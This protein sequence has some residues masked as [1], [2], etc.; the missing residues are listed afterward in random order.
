MATNAYAY[1][2]WKKSRP[3]VRQALRYNNGM[4]RRRISIL[5]VCGLHSSRAT[6]RRGN[7][8]LMPQSRL[9][10][11]ELKRLLRYLQKRSAS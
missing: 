5:R 8:V 10:A 2:L 6:D 3:L 4:I 11:V 9:P 7:P 1:D